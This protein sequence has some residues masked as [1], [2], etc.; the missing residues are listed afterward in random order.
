MLPANLAK[1]RT[2]ARGLGELLMVGP[3]LHATLRY[4]PYSVPPSS[5][6]SS[7]PSTHTHSVTSFSATNNTNAVVV[8]QSSHQMAL[9]AALAAN[10]IVPLLGQLA[11]PMQFQ[12]KPPGFAHNFVNFNSFNQI[13]LDLVMPYLSSQGGKV[14]DL[15]GLA[16]HV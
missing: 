8:A 10:E 5:S 9:S 11:P 3:G 16:I 2:A 15:S 6:S 7:S 4:S 12:S 13:P 1:G 14:G